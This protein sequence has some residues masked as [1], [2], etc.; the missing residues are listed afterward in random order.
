MAA[1]DLAGPV[2]TAIGDLA[3]DVPT[4]AAVGLG[5]GVLLYGIKRMWRFVKGL[6]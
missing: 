6:I 4:V 2:N 1:G 5:A 3:A